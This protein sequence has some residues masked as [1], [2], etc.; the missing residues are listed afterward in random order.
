MIETPTL[1]QL[2]EER[3]A[4]T[5]DAL[6]AVDESGR[7]LTFAGYRDAVLRTAGG[8][9]E[10]GVG[11][12]KTVS[13]MLPT[14]FESMILCLALSRLGAIQNP[15]IPIYR[16]REVGFIAKQARPMLL[17]TPG[18]WRGFDYEAM[19]KEIASETE[20]LQ[21]LVVNRELPANDGHPLPPPP[22]LLPPEELPIRWILY[23][24]GTTSDPKGARHTDHS[25]WCAAKALILG[26][27]LA[28]DDRTAM[29]FPVTHVGGIN[30]IQSGL[31]TGCAH[32]LIENFAAPD[33]MEILRNSGMTQAMAGT[34]FHEAYLKSQ[35]EHEGEG[36]LFPT[37][38]SFPG[39]AAPKPPKLHYDLRRE[40]GG[41]GIISGYGMTECPI[42]TMN[43]VGDSDEKLAETEG[44]VSLPEVD[45]RAVKPDGRVAAPGEEGELRVKAPNLCRGYVDASLDAAAFDENGYF[46]TGDLGVFDEDGYVVITGRLKDVIIRKGENVPAKE[47]EDILYKHDKVADVAVIGLPDAKSGERVCAV[48]ACK[49]AGD[50]LSFEEMQDFL[51]DSELM[52][53][54]IPEQLELIEEV[55]RNPTGKILKHKLRERYAD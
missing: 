19:A 13:W 23:S 54:K 24:S 55:P 43:E 14:W 2:L 30:W 17:I 11:P 25:L 40:M 51:R 48:V 37:I 44:R 9:A 45:L 49:D 7:E 22:E 35:R 50:P 16:K 15:I 53:Q 10:L 33:T 39:G 34:V 41:A 29:V 32:I 12:D 27:H 42:M 21:T 6:M 8:L 38:R 36:L 5:P 46:R 52:V 26:L 3:V 4:A 28:Q 20:G 18:Q 31:S 47:V 1:W